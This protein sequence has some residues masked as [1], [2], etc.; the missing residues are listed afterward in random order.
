MPRQRM[1]V[2]DD[3][4]LIDMD[5]LF[6]AIRE[7]DGDWEQV[8]EEMQNYLQSIQNMVT[9]DDDEDDDDSDDADEDDGDQE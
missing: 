8:E 2:T 1:I 9:S 6:N 3:Q 7:A 5:L 4:L